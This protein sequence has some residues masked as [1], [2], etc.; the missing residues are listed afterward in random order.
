M[1]CNAIVRSRNDRLP[2]SHLSGAVE[3]PLVNLNLRGVCLSDNLSSIEQHNQ[4]SDVCGKHIHLEKTKRMAGP[5][6]QHLTNHSPKQL[7]SSSLFQ[8]TRNQ[9]KSS[10]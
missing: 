3:A 1:T 10:E 7:L 5:L 9:M 2:W 8:N 6:H 4:M